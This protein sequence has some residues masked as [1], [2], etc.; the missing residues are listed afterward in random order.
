MKISNHVRQYTEN[1][2]RQYKEVKIDGYFLD[3]DCVPDYNLGNYAYEIFEDMQFDLTFLMENK[4]F[5]LLLTSLKKFLSSPDIDNKISFAD[6]FKLSLIDSF[7]PLMEKYIEEVIGEVESAD[8]LEK[9][10]KRYTYPDNGEQI[11]IGGGVEL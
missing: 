8:Y 6:E 1:L 3:L 10:F 4:N 11:W 2:I 9:G 5:N 7:R